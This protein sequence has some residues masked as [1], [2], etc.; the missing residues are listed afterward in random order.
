MSLS[1]GRFI[2][3]KVAKQIS[4]RQEVIGASK[5]LFG[6]EDPQAYSFFLAKTPF[7][8]L[9]SGIDKDG[10]QDPARQSVLDNGYRGIASDVTAEA[11][12]Y[13][14]SDDFGVRPVAGITGMNLNTH[15]RYGSLRTATVQFEVHSLE[16]MNLYEEMFMRPGY[17]ALLEWGHSVYLDSKDGQVYDM[18]PLL[19]EP[20]INKSLVSSFLNTGAS[21]DDLQNQ[22]KQTIYR[23][24]EE[25]RRK[26]D[27][28]YDG[29]YGLIKNFSWSLRTD[30][31]YSCTV[32]IVSIGTVIESLTLNANMLKDE[33]IYFYNLEDEGREPIDIVEKVVTSFIDFKGGEEIE[34]TATQEAIIEGIR[35]K[36][37][38]V[39][40]DLRKRYR[41]EATLKATLRITGDDAWDNRI[42]H[43]VDTSS[44]PYRVS[45]LGSSK[46]IPTK[47]Q[48]SLREKKITKLSTLEEVA[49]YQNF[50]GLEIEVE[51]KPG[52]SEYF[53]LDYIENNILPFV[54]HLRHQGKEK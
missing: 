38:E 44:S 51:V 28:N 11:P 25:M 47:S 20:F 6:P 27:Y 2:D 40:R 5:R 18:E 8:K 13:E 39:N 10:K 36:L 21:A 31:G 16:Q 49:E 19:S 4:K 43:A 15:N 3:K 33:V 7:I 30:G 1:P 37:P 42:V 22:S 35:K 45:I 9:T 24:I 26:T 50:D 53:R 46:V 23:A 52:T 54:N 48:S 14:Y 29:M 32:D 34:G 17:S 41:Y 12:G